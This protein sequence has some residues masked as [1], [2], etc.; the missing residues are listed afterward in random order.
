MTD[1]LNVKMHIDKLQCFSLDKY[2]AYIYENIK[3]KLKKVN[4]IT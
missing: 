3:I 1:H 4:N 2:T